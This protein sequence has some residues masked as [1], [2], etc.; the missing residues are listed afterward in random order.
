M[1]ECEWHRVTRIGAPPHLRISRLIS[2][3]VHLCI[4]AFVHSFSVF[5]LAAMA[6][7]RIVAITG[8][9][10]GIGRAT[11]LRLA[12]DGASIA[13]CARRADRLQAVAEDIMSAG[14]HALPVVA[15]VTREADMERFVAAAVDRFGRLDAIV[16]NAGFGVY[17]SADAIT[18]EQMRELLDVN[19]L[20]TFYAMRAAMP[21]FRRQ[22]AGHVIVLSSIVGKRGVPYM[23]AYAATKFAQVG[24]AECL[25]A[26]VQGSD[27]HVSV[28]FPISTETE[29]FDVMSKASGHA[30][31]AMG[32]RQHAGDVADAIARA[33]DRP[34][35]EVYPYRMARG[36]V[37]LNAVA[38]GFCDR[39]VKK[40][41]RKP[42]VPADV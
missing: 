20:G 18:S 3:F 39:L 37:L 33:L 12:R 6:S 17:G 14:G 19:Y 34:V 21:V 23:G 40:W 4:R 35:A 22:G 28:V 24:L 38:P 7:N 41:G 29:F 30:T 10:A 26:E 15:D 27:I 25:R 11:A 2:A 32:P 9:S 42:I 5:C 1:H 16:C 13:A 31:R 36:L 8:A